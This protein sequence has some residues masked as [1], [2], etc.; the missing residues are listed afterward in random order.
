[1]VK[2]LWSLIIKGAKW[3]MVKVLFVSFS[4]FVKITLLGAQLGRRGCIFKQQFTSMFAKACE[5]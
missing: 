4:I 2:T 1:V 5:T 3:V